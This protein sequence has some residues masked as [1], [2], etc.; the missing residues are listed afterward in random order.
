MVTQTLYAFVSYIFPLLSVE[1]SV[2]SELGEQLGSREKKEDEG[3]SYLL[4]I[5][6]VRNMLLHL[7]LCL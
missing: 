7:I 3:H 6:C 1:E 2:A 5:S 4:G